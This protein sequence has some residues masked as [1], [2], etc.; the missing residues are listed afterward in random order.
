MTTWVLIVYM[1]TM[2]YA[3]NATGGPVAIDGF[4]SES[5]CEVAGAKMS[6]HKK[7]DWHVCVEMK[8]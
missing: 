8:K 3:Q 1:S 4:T 6:N 2:T 5:A 7:Y